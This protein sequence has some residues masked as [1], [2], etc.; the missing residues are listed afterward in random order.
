[1]TIND[2]PTHPLFKKVSELGFQPN[3]YAIFGSGPLF[4]HNLTDEIHD[5]D[6][7]VT[8]SGWQKALTLEKLDHTDNGDPVVHIGDDI[9]IFNTWA[10]GTW[11]IQIL[12]DQ[13]EIINGLPFVKLES[14]LT[15]KKIRNK[16]KDQ[17]HIE[18]IEIYLSQRPPS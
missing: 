13:A 12:I 10:P 7:I 3:T 8:D 18:L 17:K 2:L 5:V 16:P 11:N 14:V 9:E 4:A 1:M 6:I 15:W